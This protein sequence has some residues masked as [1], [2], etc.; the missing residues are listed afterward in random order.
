MMGDFEDEINKEKDG[1]TDKPAAAKKVFKWVFI[2]DKRPADYDVEKMVRNGDVDVG[3]RLK[4]IDDLKKNKIFLAEP[5]SF[6]LDAEFVYLPDSSTAL[7]LQSI[8]ERA[9]ATRNAAVMEGNIKRNAAVRKSQ[10]EKNLAISVIAML[11][12][13]T[14]EGPILA[15]SRLEAALSR[16]PA[17][18]GRMLK[19]QKAPLAVDPSKTISLA[20]LIPF[21]LILMTITG[22]VY[23][24][25]DLTAG[26][27]ERGT[28]EILVA[29][30]VSRLALLFAKYIAVLTVAI[31]TALINLTAMFLTLRFSGWGKMVLGEDELQLDQ[32][33]ALLGLLVLFAA[34][35]SAVLLI[36]T[37]F[38]RSFKE[39]QAYLI[40]L[41]LASLGPGAAGMIPGLTLNATLAVTPLINIVL[42]AR[43]VFVGGVTA[44]SVG[45]VVTSTL[46]YAAAAIAVAARIFGAEEVLYSE[47]SGWSDFLRRPRKTQPT[48]SVSNAFVCLALMVPINFL[49]RGLFVGSE[50]PSVAEIVA[51][52]SLGSLVLFVL[53]PGLAAYWGRLDWRETFSL[54]APSW[55]TVVGGVILGLTL[56]PL[57]V[58]IQIWLHVDLPP[59]AL[60]KAQKLID[61]FQ[62]AGPVMALPLGLAALTEELFFRGYLF[63]ALQRVA[64]PWT[65]II[66]TGVLFG[67][68]HSV[69]GG[70][71][72]SEQILP[73]TLMGLA[74]GCIRWRTGS[75][76][77]GMALHLVHNVL[78]SF[79]L[80]S[81]GG[82]NET[83]P[84]MWLMASAL[85]VPAGAL[86]VYW[87]GANVTVKVPTLAV[88][89][90]RIRVGSTHSR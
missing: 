45:L 3:V 59:E 29:A 22:A 14:G 85:G 65:V 17:T 7:M 19:I 27:R 61:M 72:G 77:P 71:L 48:A 76:L 55:L 34:F 39:A 62:S 51:F 21:I 24:A 31:L 18:I 11:G 40:P 50:L 20:A 84:P 28:L 4:N 66:V 38:A 5:E 69:I 41:M 56:W 49:L 9:L 6:V 13:P 89:E 1:K 8:L 43:D 42:L 70:S 68:M 10:R 63:S 88:V 90:T 79:M 78:L 30:P 87:G 53:L 60:E 36:L 67:L 2:D 74:L 80:N 73:A 16:P 26:E 54:N 15:A 37:S 44:L 64:K 57:I 46:I 52:M 33:L 58:Q 75:V 86:L 25:I 81:I 83:V 35:F 32:V 47:Q 82:A 12:A 23:P